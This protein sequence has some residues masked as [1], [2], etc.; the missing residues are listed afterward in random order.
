[1]DSTRKDEVKLKGP[2]NQT[3]CKDWALKF[4]TLLPS[5]MF[6]RNG[7]IYSHLSPYWYLYPIENL[8]LSPRSRDPELTSVTG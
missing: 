5:A 1:M 6:I 2:L 4:P 8:T 7:V 3:H